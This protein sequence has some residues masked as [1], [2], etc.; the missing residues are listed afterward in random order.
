MLGLV[1]GF[2]RGLSGQEWFRKFRRVSF[3]FESV[4]QRLPTGRLPLLR[5]GT[6]MEG[7]DRLAAALFA[8]VGGAT[9][10]PVTADGLK[11]LVI[12]RHVVT[13]LN[14]SIPTAM[15]EYQNRSPSTRG[16]SHACSTPSLSPLSALK[17][18]RT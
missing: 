14:A 1:G 6:L 5:L 2:I 13:A 15:V 17:D 12:S 10:R 8:P 4:R 9:R 7:D 16:P 18:R 3:I 11:L